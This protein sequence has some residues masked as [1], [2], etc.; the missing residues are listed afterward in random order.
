MEVALTGRISVLAVVGGY[1]VIVLAISMVRGRVQ[2]RRAQPGPDG[3][4]VLSGELSLLRAAAVLLGPPA[5]FL[6]VLWLITFA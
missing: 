3:R 1:W 6:L 4:V 2:A 5:A